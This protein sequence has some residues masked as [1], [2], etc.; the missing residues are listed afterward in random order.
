MR[1]RAE[2]RCWSRCTFSPTCGSD[3]SSVVGGRQQAGM[4]AIADDGGRGRL[5][6]DRPELHGVTWAAYEPGVGVW[7]ATEGS[8]VLRCIDPADGGRLVMQIEVPVRRRTAAA[9][10]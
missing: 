1:V 6:W 8:P 9:P 3:A 4:I 2:G 10:H 7:L 5:L